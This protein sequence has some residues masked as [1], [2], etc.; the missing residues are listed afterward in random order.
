MSTEEWTQIRLIV[1]R[2]IWALILEMALV[3]AHIFRT[4]M[5]SL[6][7]SWRMMV[8]S[9]EFIRE[10]TL[11]QPVSIG[12]LAPPQSVALNLGIVD[13]IKRRIPGN[14][15]YSPS[16]AAALAGAL[17]IDAAIKEAADSAAAAAAASASLD[18]DVDMD[19]GGGGP[20]E[21]AD[22]RPEDEETTIPQ[23]TPPDN[24]TGDEQGM[25]QFNYLRR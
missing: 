22:Q 7:K 16:S 3:G 15:S 1:E 8:S 6:V 25:Y 23:P 12:E 17:W 9:I 5:S 14:Q 19:L 4:R 24:Q 10:E 2:D 13:A 21:G 20:S 18:V 11:G